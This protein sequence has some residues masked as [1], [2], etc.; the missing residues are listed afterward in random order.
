MSP[1]NTQGLVPSKVGVR[2]VKVANQPTG[3][4][5]VPRIT[6]VGPVWPG[7]RTW[8]QESQH[9]SSEDTGSHLEDGRRD[10]QTSKAGWIE[11]RE[12]LVP[13]GP[14]RI[15]PGPHLDTQLAPPWPQAPT[16]VRILTF[17]TC[18]CRSSTKWRLTL[19]DPV[20]CSTPGSFITITQSLLKPMSI[21]SVMPS[22]RLI[23]CCPFSCPQSFSASG[24]FPMSQLF[25]L[26]GRSIGASASA[27]VLPVNT[28]D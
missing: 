20:D 22:N 7:P 2:V 14:G 9:Q 28:Q 1:P 10:Q 15:W 4:G 8:R 13:G 16:P 11:A 27:S 19:C 3:T 12:Q 5:K 6:Q 25:I 23:L 26:C 21:E 17:R 24:S 18:C